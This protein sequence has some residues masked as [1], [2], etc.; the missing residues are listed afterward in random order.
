MSS[1]PLVSLS[2]SS[3][4]N[5]E[6]ICTLQEHANCEAEMPFMSSEAVHASREV[7]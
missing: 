1:V 5:E 4:V 3:L 6:I 7:D 2:E